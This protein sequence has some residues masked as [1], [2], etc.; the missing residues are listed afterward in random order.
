M[1]VTRVFRVRVAR[2][3]RRVA[4]TPDVK[5]MGARSAGN[6]CCG[7]RG[8]GWKRGTVGMPRPT[9]APVLD[10]T[11]SSYRRLRSGS[12]SAR[13]GQGTETLAQLGGLPASVAC[14]CA[15]HL[16]AGLDPRRPG[17]RMAAPHRLSTDRGDIPAGRCLRQRRRAG[18]GRHR[19]YY[20]PNV[21]CENGTAANSG[22]HR[23]HSASMRKPRMRRGVATWLGSGKLLGR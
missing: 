11:R 15:Q 21:R 1:A 17:Q 19:P 23:F 3:S 10:P 6:P 12:R 8:G 5:Q 16:E 14:V 7:R 18:T 13:R 4:I 9:G 22:M 20:I 2:S